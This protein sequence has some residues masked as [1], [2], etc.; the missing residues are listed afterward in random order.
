MFLFLSHIFVRM[1]HA[2]IPVPAPQ[3]SKEELGAPRL[4]PYVT[5]DWVWITPVAVLG[6]LLVAIIIMRHSHNKEFTDESS[7]SE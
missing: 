7:G 1:A 4:P 2:D 5:P 3:Y 6:G